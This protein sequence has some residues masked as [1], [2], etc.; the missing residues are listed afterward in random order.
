MKSSPI[1]VE[2]LEWL[3]SVVQS[4][5]APAD[6][7]QEA[8]GVAGQ[9]PPGLA[10]GLGGADPAWGITGADHAQRTQEATA[11]F[12]R[13]HCPV[14]QACVEEACR[15][16]R[17]EEAAQQILDEADELGPMPTLAL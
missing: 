8:A 6:T 4:D 15:V 16:W 17:L 5:A 14:N 13:D 1:I 2:P 12:C 9:V 11:A 10:A 7:E 3:Q